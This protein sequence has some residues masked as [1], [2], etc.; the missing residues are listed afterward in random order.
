LDEK[1]YEK[2]QMSWAI[3]KVW[4]KFYYFSISKLRKPL[5]QARE[6]QYAKLSAHINSL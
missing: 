2:L 1:Y 3:I 5:A 6:L 4:R